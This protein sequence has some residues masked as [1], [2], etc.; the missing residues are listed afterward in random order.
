MIKNILLVG[1]GGSIGSM[2]RYLV[3]HFMKPGSFPWATLTVNI[4]GSF[5]I[6]IIF[7]LAARDEYFSQNWR[8]FLAAG[9]CGGFTTFSAF[10]AENLLLLQQGKYLVAGGYI[11]LSVVSGILAAWIG[12]KTF[13]S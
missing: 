11:L 3:S 8:L 10:S 13:A 1:L 6:G 7:A 12:F 9:I 4:T 2:G 5:I